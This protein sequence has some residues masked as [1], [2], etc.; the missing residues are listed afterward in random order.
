[1][2]SNLAK[3]DIVFKVGFILTKQEFYSA[4]LTPSFDGANVKDKLH[5]LWDV[6]NQ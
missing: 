3:L 1:M 2:F 4:A 6:I 5:I